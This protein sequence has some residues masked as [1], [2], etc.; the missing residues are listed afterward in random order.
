MGVLRRKYFL[1]GSFSSGIIGEAYE[2][3]ENNQAVGKVVVLV[4]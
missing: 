3:M 4:P 1:T 2:Y